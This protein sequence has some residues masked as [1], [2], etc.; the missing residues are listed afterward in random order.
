MRV[1]GLL[2]LAIFFPVF[3]HAAVMINEIMYKSNTTSNSGREWIEIQNTGSQEVD[4]T[5]VSSSKHW[6]LVETTNDGKTVNTGG[7]KPD[8]S[9][10]VPAGGIAVLAIATSTFLADWP[11]WNG[12]LFDITTLTSLNDTGATLSIIDVSG[13]TQNTV[14]YVNTMGAAGDGKSLQ[15]VNGSW[16]A[17]TPTPGAINAGVSVP[18]SDSTPSNT[19]S[20]TTSATE[21]TTIT[22]SSGGPAEYLPIPTL[23]IVTNGDRT[24]SSGADTAFT[25]AVYDGKG[26]KR[27]DALVTWSFGDGMR[28][29]GASVFHSYYVSGE[30]L[31]IIRASTSDGGNASS[32]MIITVKDAGIKIVSVSPR[33]IALANND[34][35]TLD[36]SLWRLSMGGQEFKIP[37]DTQILAG[38]TILFPSQVIELP[39]ADSAS[40]LYPSGEIAA[41][42]PLSYKG[43]P[44]APSTSL[45]TIQAVDSITNTKANVQIYEEAVSAPATPTQPVGAAGAALSS[46]SPEADTPTQVSSFSKILHSPWTIGFLS[47]VALAGGAFIFI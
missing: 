10:I 25:A 12:I 45:N 5:Y 46:S 19:S 36:L 37:E 11:G 22:S 1:A 31:A 39:I 17:A 21:T 13:T 18:S 2:L 44:S 6:K 28:K 4:L 26:N 8:S 47:V 38:H 7:I 35:R 24:V 34:S 27:D 9:G 41:V 20:D 30:Y 23:R 32:E 42:Y 14:S 15:L 3:A 43:Q 16:V 40:L 33:G 29:T